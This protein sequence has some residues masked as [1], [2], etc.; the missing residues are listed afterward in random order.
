[1]VHHYLTN[2]SEHEVVAFTVNEEFLDEP[3]YK[4][5]PVVPFETVE[6]PYPPDRY[7][8]YVAMGYRRMNTIRARLYEEAKA[9]GYE[10]I[11][12]I[13]S[14]CSFE[15][16]EIGDN[17]FIFE[18][19]TIQPYVR[20]GNDVVIWSGTHVGHRAKIG[21]HCFISSQIVISGYVE[22]GPYCFCGVN[23]TFRDQLKIGASTL[24]G[25]GALIMR[26]TEEGEVY[27]AQR[28]KPRE[29]KSDEIDF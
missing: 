16:E 24:V 29:Q 6:E 18:E 20:I 26:D 17:C 3:E 25:A 21:D 13:S 15:A 7:A 19:N 28:T 11:T 14:N 23:A 8:M 4:G 27:V 1:M 22:M 10:L 2:D 12:Y 9:K 5:L